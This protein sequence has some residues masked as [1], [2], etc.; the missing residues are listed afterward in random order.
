[1]KSY[2]FRVVV[3]PD[4]ERW[5]A[6][7]PAVKDRGG[8]T[9]GET[10][11]EALKNIQEV[12]QMTVES[13]MDHGETIPEDPSSDVQVFPEPRVAVTLWVKSISPDSGP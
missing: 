10:P 2:V 3:E 5:V 8:A 7:A 6:Y 12:L 9:W 11:E 13:M 1:M 4:E